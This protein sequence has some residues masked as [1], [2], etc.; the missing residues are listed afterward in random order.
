M[1]DAVVARPVM[2][3]EIKGALSCS[4]VVPARN[5]SGN[6]RVALER[7]PMLGE[8]TEVIF[9]EDNSA[10]DTWNVNQQEAAAYE[11]PHRVR[12]Y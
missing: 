6:I 9:I 4:V 10:D 2:E 1:S 12:S 5:E 7:I 11:G 3:P 8:Q